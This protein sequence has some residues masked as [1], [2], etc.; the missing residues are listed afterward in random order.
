MCINHYII[1]D[2]QWFF[3]TKNNRGTADFK[4]TTP[5]GTR[6]FNYHNR[7]EILDVYT[8]DKYGVK[9]IQKLEKYYIPMS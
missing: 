9:I 5:K 1:R 7:N 4:S 3:E 2:T 8:K 6:Y